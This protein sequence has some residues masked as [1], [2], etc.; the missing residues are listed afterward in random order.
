MLNMNYSGDGYPGN[1]MRICDKCKAAVSILYCPTDSAYLCNSCD[2]L[3]HPAN[4]MA[5]LHQRVWIFTACEN[6]PTAFTCETDAVPFRVSCDADINLANKPAHDLV[7]VAEPS[8]SSLPYTTS[9]TYLEELADTMLDTPNEITAPTTEEVDQDEAD[10][11]LLLEPEPDNNN[12]QTNSGF[13]FSEE[14]DESF[15]IVEHNSCTENQYQDLNNQQQLYCAYPG[16]NGTDGIVPVQ[17]S[18]VKEQEKRN[19]YFNREYEASKAASMNTPSS[20]HIELF[21]G[22][23]LR[24]SDTVAYM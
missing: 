3:I 10:S 23:S 14:L 21:Y 4:S 22:S 6:E 7:Q 13:T 16:D 17:S 11:W 8:L 20:S 24:S 2:E 1:W 5:S 19:V 18:E 15:S 9:S 12:N